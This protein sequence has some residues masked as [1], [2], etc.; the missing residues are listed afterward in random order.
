M[1]T[2]LTS[3]Q[4][5]AL[6]AIAAACAATGVMHYGDV[7]GTT[8]FPVATI[9]LA[10]MA[11]M[12][13][14]A[15]HALSTHFGPGLTGVIQSTLGN[16]P[17][18]CVVIFALHDGQTVVAQTSIIG[19]LFVNALLVL[20]VVIIAGAIRSGDGVMRFK[21]RLPNDTSTLLLMAV[22]L[23]T[24]LGVAV[25][26]GDKAAEHAKTISALGAILLLVVYFTWLYAY[27]KADVA[28]TAAEAKAEVAADHGLVMPLRGALTM[29]AIAGVG[30]AFV[31]EWFVD[32]LQPAIHSLHLS[33]AFAGLVIV[34]IAG[35]AVENVAGIS[36]AWKGQMDEAISIVKNSVS[37][38]AVFLFP[39]LVLIS[40]LLTSH[41]TF[42]L[43]PVY[44]A[45]LL[46][47]ALAMWQVTGD[48]E[49]TIFEGAAL[50][51]LYV[52]LGILTFYE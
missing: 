17:E 24:V 32:S 8:T 2:A 9:A 15:T 48:G 46:V 7:A 45:A 49:A 35:N 34:A 18:L 13:S 3:R 6:L 10:G 29:L 26:T 41:L 22:F 12:V 25:G 20:G 40:L 37:Q 14:L 1:F 30:A 52:M 42:V 23:I 47:T 36:L 16:L 38:I 31:S 5:I 51:S 27:L 11:W 4:R 33:Q 19:S 43:A 21:P 28:E 50:I 39:L 44:I